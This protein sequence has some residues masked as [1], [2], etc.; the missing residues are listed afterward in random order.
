MLDLYSGVIVD[1]FH[2]SGKVDVSR[3]RLRRN[4]N[5]LIKIL[6][7]IINRLKEILATPEFLCV[8]IYF[9]SDLRY[10][11]EISFNMNRN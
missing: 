7:D 11:Y 1:S 6:M 3:Q 9:I 4:L 5:W 8:S 10:S 2:S